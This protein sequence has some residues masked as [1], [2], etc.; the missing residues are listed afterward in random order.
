[1]IQAFQAVLL[2][3]G[4]VCLDSC[5]PVGQRD[6]PVGDARPVVV[7]GRTGFLA[8]AYG[9]SNRHYPDIEVNCSCTFVVSSAEVSILRN[10][11][12]R[13]LLV[14]ADSILFDRAS[15]SADSLVNLML[16]AR[17]V[18]ADGPIQKSFPMLRYLEVTMP[19][20]LASSLFSQ[21]LSLN[22]LVVD[23]AFASTKP[24]VE[25]DC[26]GTQLLLRS[27]MLTEFDSL[28]LSFLPFAIVNIQGTPLGGRLDSLCPQRS[29]CYDLLNIPDSTTIVF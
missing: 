12:C 28:Y 16:S 10:L 22:T 25:Y 13:S 18:S 7:D 8:L 2:F 14:R 6:I 1:M 19:S 15:V 11:Q 21:G 29:E 26:A 5:E 20:P 27:P 23:G 17:Y 3:C 4:M 9:A 24:L